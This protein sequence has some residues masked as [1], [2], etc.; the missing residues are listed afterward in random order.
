[1]GDEK[2]TSPPPQNGMSPYVV[3]LIGLVLLIGG[4]KISTWVPPRQGPQ[5]ELFSSVRAKVDDPELA[6]R[7][8]DIGLPQPPF[9]FAGRV[10]FFLGLGLFVLAL[11]TMWRGPA[12]IEGPPDAVS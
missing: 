10:A 12:P 3:G 2:E 8:D 11:A 7:M 5:G 9:E 6:R 1:M 4:W